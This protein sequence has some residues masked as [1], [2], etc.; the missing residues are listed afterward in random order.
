MLHTACW[1]Y[2]TQ[3]IAISAPLHNFV[4]LYLRN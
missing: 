1:K 2:K 3:K 4:R